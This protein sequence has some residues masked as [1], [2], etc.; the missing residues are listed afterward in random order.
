MA[1]SSVKA[2]KRNVKVDP[3][4]QAHIQATFNNIIVSLT[5]EIG[6]AHV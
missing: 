6:R 3:V 5:N 1:K 2:K 4:G